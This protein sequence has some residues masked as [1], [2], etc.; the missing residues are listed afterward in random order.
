M[1]PQPWKL[2]F[3]VKTGLPLNISFTFHFH[4]SITFH[5]IL[6][7]LTGIVEIWEGAEFDFVCSMHSMTGFC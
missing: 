2:Q 1:F 4:S 5:A 3:S 6:L 7:N